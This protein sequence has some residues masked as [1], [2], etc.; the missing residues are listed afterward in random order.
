MEGAVFGFYVRIFFGGRFGHHQRKCDFLRTPSG[1]TENF[2]FPGWPVNMLQSGSSSTHL[3]PHWASPEV[4]K[5]ET[6]TFGRSE[7]MLIP[8]L[9]MVRTTVFFDFG[10]QVKL[11]Q[12]SRHLR[13]GV[14][15]FLACVGAWLPNGSI[16]RLDFK[17][18]RISHLSGAGV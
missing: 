1:R 15:R 6:G 2:F 18:R 13:E 12:P 10:V 16:K 14:L 9:R 4:G 7:K 11:N 17:N 5:R 3:D 8:S